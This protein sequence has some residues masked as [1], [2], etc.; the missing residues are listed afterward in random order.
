MAK[1]S[2]TIRRTDLEGGAWTLVSD[3]GLVYQLKGG[4]SGL[5]V[6]GARAEIEGKLETSLMGLAMVGEI[7]SV[8]SFR[9]LD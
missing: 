2:G 8:R 7:L 5:R 1:Y 4:G 6:D 3:Q 9:L